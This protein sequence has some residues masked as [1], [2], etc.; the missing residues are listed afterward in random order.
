MDCFNYPGGDMLPTPIHAEP[1]IRAAIA[2]V[3][4]LLGGASKTRVGNCNGAWTQAGTIELAYHGPSH[5]TPF[6]R[7]AA[8]VV[9]CGYKLS[10][11]SDMSF[12]FDPNTD[13]S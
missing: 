4:R 2:V 5:T 3:N 1:E 13:Q 11:V 8:H 10:T 9:Q 6:F 7:L 12:V